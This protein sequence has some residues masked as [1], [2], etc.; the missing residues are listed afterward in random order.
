MSRDVI[1]VNDDD[2]IR[3]VAEIMESK[4]GNELL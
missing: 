2:D 4:Q 1:C 3:K